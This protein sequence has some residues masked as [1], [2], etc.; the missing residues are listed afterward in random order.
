M[1]PSRLQD[2]ATE[3]YFK[4]V[5]KLQNVLPAS[6]NKASSAQTPSY[7]NS[8]EIFEQFENRMKAFDPQWIAFRN[9]VK[10]GIQFAV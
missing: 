9:V 8:L 2:D 1:L 5:L 4:R 6:Q 7:L 10:T 3:Q